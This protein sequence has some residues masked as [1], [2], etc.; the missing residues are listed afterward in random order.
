MVLLCV[1]LAFG[2]RG[3]SGEMDGHARWHSFYRNWQRPDGK[4]SCCNARQLTPW[5]QE[6]G[7]CEPTRAEFRNGNWYAW[8]RHKQQWLKIPDSK[9]I[10]E[11]NPSVEEGHLCWSQDA[12]ILCFVPPDTGG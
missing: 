7:D 9:I 6:L 11:R 3:Q 4:G 12:G 2:A 10:H 5:G 1:M 8:E